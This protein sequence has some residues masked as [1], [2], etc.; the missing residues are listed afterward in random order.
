MH[1]Y[2]NRDLEARILRDIEYFPVVAILG[3]RQ[4]G[5]STFE[6]WIITPLDEKYE[7][8]KYIHVSGLKQFIDYLL[9]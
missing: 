8:K 3:A 7:L 4:S 6:A 2:V 1:S 5:K 9:K